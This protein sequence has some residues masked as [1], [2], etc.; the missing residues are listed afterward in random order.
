MPLTDRH[1]Q[2]GNVAI[3]EALHQRRQNGRDS[4]A[5]PS[6]RYSVRSLERTKRLMRARALPVTTKFSQSGAGVPGLDV[7]IST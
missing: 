1:V 3:P 2:I 4:M 7:T 5:S 6:R